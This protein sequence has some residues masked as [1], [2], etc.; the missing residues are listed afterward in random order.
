MSSEFNM[1][2]ALAFAALIFSHQAAGKISAPN[3][4]AANLMPALTLVCNDRFT[5]LDDEYALASIC[6][7]ERNLLAP[8][9]Q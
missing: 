8:D 5:A 2:V 6:Q 3:L 9:P 4:L 1:V 7:M